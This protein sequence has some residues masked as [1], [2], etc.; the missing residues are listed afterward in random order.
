M[1][2]MTRLLG[3]IKRYFPVVETVKGW[4]TRGNPSFAPAAT[5]CHW[6]AGPRRTK[7]RASLNIVTHGRSDLP[8]PLCNVYLDR[9]GIPVIVAA[10]RANHAGRPDGGSLRGLRGNSST[11]GIEAEAGGDGDWTPAQEMAYPRLVRA[12]NDGLD[13]DASWAFGHNE[14][15]P[16]RKIDIR[17]WT[18]NDMRRQ[19]AALTQGDEMPLTAADIKTIADAVESRLR[20]AQWGDTDAHTVENLLRRSAD[21]ARIGENIASEQQLFGR[22]I[23]NAES[24][25]VAARDLLTVALPGQPQPGPKHVK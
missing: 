8:G 2:Y 24:A 25:A 6:T 10:G 19:V 21:A 18:M 9:D 11:Y 7:R 4:E 3:D 23:E 17:D 12:M 13:R 20:H 15:A 14:W 5:V 1:P 16:T 22:R